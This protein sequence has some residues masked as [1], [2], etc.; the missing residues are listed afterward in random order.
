MRVYLDGVFDMFHV[1]HLRAIQHCA[2][3]GEVLIGVI[4]D[5]DA[6]AYKRC[7][8]IAEDDR[9]AIVEAL[10]CV[11]AVIRHPPLVMTAAFMAEHAIDLVVH[12]FADAADEAAQAD[13]FRVPREMGKFRAIAYHHGI[14]TTQIRQKLAEQS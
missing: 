5:E 2:T 1:G 4:S 8:T 9:A 12:G 3:L 6:T 10:G 14:S 11:H 7:P 13:L